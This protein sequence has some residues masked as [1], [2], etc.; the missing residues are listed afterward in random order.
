[1]EGG[2]RSMNNQE[3][4]PIN[5]L[6]DNIYQQ[7]PNKKKRSCIIK[8]DN[9]KIT[10][11]WGENA[12]PHKATVF[13]STDKITAGIFLLTPGSWCTP[14]HH[15]GDEYYYVLDGVLTITINDIDTYDVCEGEGFLIATG[16]KHQV[17]NFTEKMCRVSFAI[18]GGL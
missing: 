2:G 13:V 12:P 6:W 1:M 18:G 3:R 8:K 11:F 14:S 17:F 4:T 15:K 9:A 10:N 7:W 5:K 16:D